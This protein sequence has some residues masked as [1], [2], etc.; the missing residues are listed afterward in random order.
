MD[1][2][3]VLIDK[4]PE[5]DLIEI[6]MKLLL[7]NF[8]TINLKRSPTLFVSFNNEIGSDIFSYI[9]NNTTIM[10]LFR[11]FSTLQIEQHI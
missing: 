9:G 5:E 7:N 3:Y 1:S 2:K 10:F 6:Q 8:A 11:Q 4:F